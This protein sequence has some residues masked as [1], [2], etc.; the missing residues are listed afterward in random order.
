MVNSDPRTPKSFADI[1]NLTDSK[2]QEK[3]N[4]AVT[5]KFNQFIKRGS[6]IKTDLKEVLKA[7]RK[8]I[9]VKHVFKIKDKVNGE[10]FKDRVVVKGYMAVPGL[11]YTEKFSPCMT[12][13][14]V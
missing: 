6:W 4:A 8:P 10:R 2:V 14:T 11:D 7:G 5:D 1:K 9:P 3:W 13:A 12:D